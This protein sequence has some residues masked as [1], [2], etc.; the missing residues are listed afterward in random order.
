MCIYY[1]NNR[2]MTSQSQQYEFAALA[3]DVV[4][5]TVCEEQLHV[6]LVQM[7]KKPFTGMW[8]LPGGLVKPNEDADTA[9]KRQLLE[10]TGVSNAYLEQLYTFSRVDRDPFGRVVSVAYYAL[11]PKKTKVATMPDYAD[12]QWVPVTAVMS[13]AYDHRDILQTAI[14]RLKSKL[15]YTNIVYSLLPKEFTLSE[16][17]SVYE[18][19]LDTVL[20]KRNFRKKILAQGMIKKTGKKQTAGANRP[21]EL[22]T[23]IKRSVQEV[24]M[25]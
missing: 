13:L 10:K 5:F 16:M 22:Y 6:L 8:A 9:A 15:A 1:T 12:I 3:T 23:F 7:N 2:N 4:I 25:L 19:I 24:A 20:D 18:L 14:V 11:L 17:Q 21:A